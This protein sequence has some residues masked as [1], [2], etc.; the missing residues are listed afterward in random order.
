MYDFHSYYAKGGIVGYY[1]D[2]AVSSDPVAYYV[3]TDDDVMTIATAIA[4]D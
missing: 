2:G 1:S 3:E 4:K